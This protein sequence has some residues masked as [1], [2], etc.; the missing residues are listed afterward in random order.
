MALT[1][2]RYTAA[3]AQLLA[4]SLALSQVTPANSALNYPVKPVRVVIP[5]APGGGVDIVGRLTGAKLGEEYKQQ[6][7]ADNRMGGGG[8]VGNDIVAK[9]PAD[10]YTLLAMNS[11]LT[12]LPALYPKI[13]YVTLREFAPITLIGVTPSV[14]VVNPAVPAKSTRELIALMKAKPGQINY[15][16]GVGGTL[17]LA[18]ALFEDMAGVK[19][20]LIPYKGGGPALIDTV[21]GQVQMMIVPVVSA[22]GH[23]KSN[24]LRAL[25]VSGA[26]RSPMLPDVPTIADTGVPGYEYITWYGL[27]APAATPRPIIARLNQSVARALAGA[28]LRERFAQQGV[29]V[30]ASTPEQFTALLQKELPRWAQ[31]IKAA[32]IQG[33]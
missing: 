9:A 30:E 10:G 12:Y 25:G 14:L 21:S 5:Y 3:L 2:L 8:I 1:A 29:E 7:I 27:L 11:A 22:I 32:K 16:A 18:V 15:A 23:I 31:I 33:E 13:P 6:F 19:G 24:R 17:H 20:T 4:S 26:R 28:E